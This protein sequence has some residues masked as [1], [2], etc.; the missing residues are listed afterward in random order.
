M[1]N[2]NRA[3]ELAANRVEFGMS[4]RVKFAWLIFLI[5]GI[6]VAWHLFR[7]YD[8]HILNIVMAACCALVVLMIV[9]SLPGTIVIA[10]D[11]LQQFHWVRR[12]K[13]IHWSDIVEINAGK[14]NRTIT[15][16]AG[17]GTKIVHSNEL[18]DRPRFLVEIKKH[19]GENLPADF[20]GE[21]I[22]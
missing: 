2:K 4:W 18:A 16:T 10:E 9:S 7:Q 13:H 17:D 15:I 21:P 6:D 5:A 11:G 12:N 20:P 22:F 1:Q 8:E 14:N 3:K 19:C